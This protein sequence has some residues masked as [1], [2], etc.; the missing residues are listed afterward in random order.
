MA[1]CINCKMWSDESTYRQLCMNCFIKR[2][3]TIKL[4]K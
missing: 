4:Y 3:N 1:K 2:S